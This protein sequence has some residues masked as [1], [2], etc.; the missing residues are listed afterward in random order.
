MLA[1]R[2]TEDAHRFTS[3]WNF[4]P[5]DAD[6]KPVSWIAD[7]LVRSWGDGAAWTQDAATHPREA[8]ALKLDASKAKTC[9]G[10]HPVLPLKPALQ[11]IV[12]W[13][14]AFQAGADLQQLTRTQIER[15]EALSHN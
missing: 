10:W 3:G 13:Y 5:A 9:L 6:A 4:G 7:E 12:E 8:H 15:Y 11:W 2:L 14:R 1:E